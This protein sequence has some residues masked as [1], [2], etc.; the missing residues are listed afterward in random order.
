MLNDGIELILLTTID[1]ELQH[2][3]IAIPDF[4]YVLMERL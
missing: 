2:N 1:E 3:I 4:N